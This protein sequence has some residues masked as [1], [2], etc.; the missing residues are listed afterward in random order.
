MRSGSNH[1]QIEP[2]ANALNALNIL[3]KTQWSI[4]LDFLDFVSILTLDGEKISPYPI[5]IRQSAWQRSDNLELREIFIE[6]NE[7]T[8]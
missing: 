1:S 3:Q 7:S 5:D 4:N 2:S 8:C 6:K